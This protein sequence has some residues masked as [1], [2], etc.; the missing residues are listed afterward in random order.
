MEKALP[1]VT[2]PQTYI[3][4]FVCMYITAEVRQG[5]LKN[6]RRWQ[7]WV[8]SG[9]KIDLCSFPCISIQPFPSTLSL[10]RPPNRR[11]EQRRV[12]IL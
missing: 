4:I 2:V 6:E 7:G 12:I 8:K 3:H 11:D 1:A 5:L 9:H 10:H